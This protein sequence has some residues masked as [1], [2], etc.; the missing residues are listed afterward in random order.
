MPRDLIGRQGFI[1]GNE[2]PAARFRASR[3]SVD[4][5]AASEASQLLLAGSSLEIWP[6]SVFPLPVS[7]PDNKWISAPF[8]SPIASPSGQEGQVLLQGT[9]C[10]VSMY[11][12]GELDW[13]IW[14]HLDEA[15]RDAMIR[16]IHD[17]SD[18]T[19]NILP[20]DDY[21]GCPTS[22]GRFAGIFCELM[23]LDACD[24][25]LFYS[26]DVR[27][28]FELDRDPWGAQSD[29]GDSTRWPTTLTNG[30]T[31]SLQ[32][33]F[34]LETQHGGWWEIHPLDSL[35]YQLAARPDA[36][37][38]RIGAFSNSNLHKIN[39]CD[40]GAYLDSARQTAWYLDLP[41]LAVGDGDRVNVDVAEHVFRHGLE[42]GAI[43]GPEI[44]LGLV[45]RQPQTQYRN[46]RARYEVLPRPGVRA[47][48]EF[49]I[50]PRDGRRKVWI[51]IIT[52]PPDAFGSML[53]LDV[54][55]SMR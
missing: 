25:G 2:F 51:G 35:A 5:T 36:I 38:W 30:R 42:E 15:R 11:A 40:G 14:L 6:P 34:V 18:H 53:G 4:P 28:L 39:T 33:N 1:V 26:A 24:H 47:L 52:D 8:D 37:I 20:E 17:F 13:H 44:G 3:F 22:D 7:C 29:P 54:T 45:Y 50:D 16:I 23:V 10:A 27:T 49:P 41:E 21:E 32:G 9:V 55:L 43:P 19:G 31:V 12:S 46:Y 48:S